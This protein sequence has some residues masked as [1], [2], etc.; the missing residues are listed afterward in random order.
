M[1]KRSDE[2]K[3]VVDI[4]DYLEAH[5]EMSM[6]ERDL[7]DSLRDI[8]WE[9]HEMEMHLIHHLIENEQKIAHEVL[10]VSWAKLKAYR[11]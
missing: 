10:S 7:K 6:R 4:G 11:G 3:R 9:Q 5:R 8:K 2:M 1:N